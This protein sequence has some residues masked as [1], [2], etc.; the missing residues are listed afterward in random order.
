VISADLVVVQHDPG[1]DAAD[2]RVLV[3][4]EAR[5]W[6]AAADYDEREGDRRRSYPAAVV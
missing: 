4:V 5:P 6:G 3:E 2:D 1:R